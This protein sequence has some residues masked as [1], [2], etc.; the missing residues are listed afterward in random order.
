MPIARGLKPI[1][2]SCS[3]SF[4]ITGSSA[5]FSWSPLF[6]WLA[7]AWTC[8]I[9]IVKSFS[10]PKKKKSIR[11]FSLLIYIRKENFLIAMNYVRVQINWLD[12][13]WTKEYS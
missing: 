2:C 13:K 9:R 7:L 4:L 5:A 12:R 3:S 10:I 1:T 8:W 6:C 11:R